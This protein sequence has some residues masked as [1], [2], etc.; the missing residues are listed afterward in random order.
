MRKKCSPEFLLHL[1]FH[2]QLGGVLLAAKD[3]VFMVF[4]NFNCGFNFFRI[5]RT[6]LT[7]FNPGGGRFAPTLTYSR[8]H[9]HVCIQTC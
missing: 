2:Q 1:G 4:L 6:N 3:M 5:A 9:A 7:L 8:I